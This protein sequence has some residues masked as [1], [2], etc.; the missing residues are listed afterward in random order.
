MRPTY[1]CIPCHVNHIYRVLTKLLLNESASLKIMQEL[2]QI[3]A[4]DF[5]SP[6]DCAYE[7]Y[8]ALSNLTGI[9]DP[10]AHEK[11]YSNTTMLSLYPK[12]QALCTSIV[13]ALKVALAANSID[14]GIGDS[15]YGMDYFLTIQN[16]VQSITVPDDFCQAFAD[17]HA[18][19]K[20][21]LYIADNAGEIVADMLLIEHLSTHKIVCAVRG[22]P[23]INDATLEDA[24]SIG[25]TKK[26]KV[27]S[28]GDRTPGINLKRCSKEFL[29]ELSQAD[30][31]IAKGQGN[32]E[33]LIDA[34][35]EGFVKKGVKL[36]F[37]FKVKCLPVAQ[38]INK[39][40]GDSA[41]I[42]RKV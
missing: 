21:I 20:K 19:S 5:E 16:T 6:P 23:V 25:L 3:I 35:L 28:T 10:F 42:M 39:S 41:F 32:F 1:H 31:I 24:Q 27:I 18:V 17:L 26:V 13:Q 33:T 29:D 2:T 40:I 36:F 8:T 37:I 9:H 4:G 12:L 34:K 14:Y 7:L 38:Y 11:S 22:A 30:M 15:N